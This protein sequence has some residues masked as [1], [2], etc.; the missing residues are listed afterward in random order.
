MDT[1]QIERDIKIKICD[2]ITFVLD[3]WD[4]NRVIVNTPFIFED[5]DVIKVVLKKEGD[6]WYFTD[7]GHTFMHLSYDDLDLTQNT[8]KEII[9]KILIMHDILNHKGELSVKVENDLFGDALF[10]FLQGLN[11]MSDLS[12]TKKEHVKS[13]FLSEFA[14]FLKSLLGDKA[15]FDYID[16][17]KDKKG[18]YKVDCYIP[19]RRPIFIFGVPSSDKCRDTTITL[20][21]FTTWNVRFTSI[22]IY[23]DMESLPKRAVAKLTDVSDKSYSNLETAKDDLSRY[24]KQTIVD[25]CLTS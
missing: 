11:R 8:R 25:E 20:L 24:L 1:S 6:K 9:D 16:E 12:F 21:K 13:L 18:K 14:D 2:A 23:E 4:K 10:N 3:E 19:S 22:T 5:G 7:E 15:I 17:D